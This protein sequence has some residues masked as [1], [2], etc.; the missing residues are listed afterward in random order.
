MKITKFSIRKRPVLPPSRA[1]KKARFFS[2]GLALLALGKVYNVLVG[3]AR[4][5][6]LSFFLSNFQTLVIFSTKTVVITIM[7]TMVIWLV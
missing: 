2:L 7:I 6:R 5:K 4:R 3:E 1:I